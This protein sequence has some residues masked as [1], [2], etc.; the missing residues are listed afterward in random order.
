MAQDL[1]DRF[2]P[3]HSHPTN[4]SSSGIA[5]WVLRF[6]HRGLKFPQGAV[7]E[8]YFA[9]VMNSLYNLT[10]VQATVVWTAGATT[11]GVTWEGSFE[12][13]AADLYDYSAAASFAT[14]KTAVSLALTGPNLARYTPIQFS[15]LEIGGLL[16]LESYRFKL[17]RTDAVAMDA[18]VY[19]VLLQNLI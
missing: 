17:R 5:T 9:S 13:Q 2:T 8:A 6:G 15:N 1:I 19:R 10:G 3:I 7:Y 4:V 11:A 16:P 18:F 12:R 14:A